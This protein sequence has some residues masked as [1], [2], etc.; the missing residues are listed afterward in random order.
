M[1]SSRNNQARTPGNVT[2]RRAGTR[3][4]STDPRV[5]H[6]RRSNDCNNPNITKYLGRSVVKVK[7]KGLNLNGVVRE[8]RVGV[9]IFHIDV[10]EE[11][12]GRSFIVP[13]VYDEKD[14]LESVTGGT[15]QEKLAAIDALLV[16]SNISVKLA[17]V[18][19]APGVIRSKE[20]K[21]LF[22]VRYGNK[23]I[24]TID[25]DELEKIVTP[26]GQKGPVEKIIEELEGDR[27]KVKWRKRRLLWKA[28]KMKTH[29]KRNKQRK[30]GQGREEERVGISSASA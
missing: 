28:Q 15:L 6:E 14:L 20:V 26:F 25:S 8:A 10:T 2:A 29:E 27:F 17:G 16:G 4:N 23:E 13:K 21:D 5:V 1:L 30:K 7:R 18:V 19:R 11:L 22:V 9:S 24:E 3:D 12:D